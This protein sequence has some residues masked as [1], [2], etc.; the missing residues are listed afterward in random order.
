MKNPSVQQAV[1]SERQYQEVSVCLTELAAK[2]R[3]S[4]VILVDSSGHVLA[5]KVREA[6]AGSST[7]STLAASTYAASAEMARILGEPGNFKMVL[8]EGSTRN[9][10]VSSVNSDTFLVI[11]F[12]TGVAVGM[13]RLFTKKTLEALLPVISR[14]EGSTRM[15]HLIDRDFKSLLDERLDSTFKEF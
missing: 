8:H 5:R 7:L 9:V 4:A 3:I 10:F 1:L 2:L 6:F 15:D 11:V 13:V 12:E 14:S